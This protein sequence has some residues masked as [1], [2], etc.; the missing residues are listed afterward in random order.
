[1]AAVICEGENLCDFPQLARFITSV[2]FYLVII[3]E[4]KSQ[5]CGMPYGTFEASC[6]SGY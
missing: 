2:K 1:M 5:E 4:T 3:R 6:L